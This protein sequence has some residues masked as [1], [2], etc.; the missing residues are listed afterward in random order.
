MSQ[1]VTNKSGNEVEICYLGS[2]KYKITVYS[3]NYKSAEKRLSSALEKIQKSIGKKGTFS[4][5]KAQT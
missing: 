1:V 4:F 3:D 2:P 5:S